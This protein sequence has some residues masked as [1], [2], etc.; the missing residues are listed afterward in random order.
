M[1]RG[2]ADESLHRWLARPSPP[3]DLSWLDDMTVLVTGAGGSIGGELCRQ[4]AAVG[5]WE[6]HRLVMVDRDDNGLLRTLYDI[7]RRADCTRPEL[8]VADVTEVDVHSVM[9]MF[10]P[11]VVFHAAAFKD[12]VLGQTNPKLVVATNVGGT[13]RTL[14]AAWA[15]GVEVFVNVSTDK[16]VEPTSI[17]GASKRLAERMVARHQEDVRY[18]SVRFGNVVGSQASSLELFRRQI[19]GGGPVTLVHPDVARYWMTLGEAVSL[20]LTAGRLAA[21]GTVTVL[22]MGPEVHV[23]D[24]VLDVM[25]AEGREVDIEWIGLRP[26]EKLHEA[27]IAEEERPWYE[28]LADEAGN[29]LPMWTVPVVP[30][31]LE[32]EF[33]IARELGRGRIDARLVRTGLSEH[34][35]A[36]G[37]P[38]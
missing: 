17:M 27:L 3:S 2:M 34:L 12:V 14:S 24:M 19:L 28:R 26:G 1:L 15:A 23:F 25:R 8:V 30:I 21:A 4:L 10:T 37:R 33:E 22:D 7:D 9:Q 6:E 36:A 35:A 18:V 38:S 32:E 11:D 31:H 16:A 5:M 20:M 29:R 13:D